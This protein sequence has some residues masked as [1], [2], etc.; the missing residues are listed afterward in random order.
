MERQLDIP[1]D[2]IV[3]NYPFG[4]I[5]LASKTIHHQREH[6]KQE[7]LEAELVHIFEKSE[8]ICL[9]QLAGMGDELYGIQ[10]KDLQILLSRVNTLKLDGNL[11]EKVLHKTGTQ[12]SLSLVNAFIPASKHNILMQ[13]S[14]VL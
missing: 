11:E 14:H 2:D 12:M 1:L 6:P 9:K 7:I 4:E 10:N 13:I 5:F 8:K 3:I